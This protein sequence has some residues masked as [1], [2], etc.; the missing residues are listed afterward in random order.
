[1]PSYPRHVHLVRLNAPSEALVKRGAILLEDAL[2]TASLPGI[3]DGRLLI[4]RFLNVGNIDT[5]Q[6]AASLALIVEKRLW[7]LSSTAIHAENPGANDALAVYFRDETEP[8]ICLAKRLAQQASTHAWFWSKAIPDWQPNLSKNEALHRLIFGVMQISSKMVAV[9]ALITELLEVKAIDPLLSV[10]SEQDGAA[11][12]R[13][14]GWLKPDI[15]IAFVQPLTTTHYLLSN[16]AWFDLLQRWAGRWGSDDTRSIWLAAIALIAEKP[17]RVLDPLLMYQAQQL[18][19]QVTAWTDTRKAGEEGTRK[20]SDKTIENSLS[21]FSSPSSLFLEKETSKQEHTDK[22]DK[23]IENSLA[24]FSSP[25]SLFLEKGTSKQ[26]H[27]DN[28][29]KTIESSFLTLPTSPSSEQNWSEIPRLTEYAGLFFLFP[30]LNSLDITAFLASHPHFIELDLPRRLLY[31]VGQR[32][33]IPADDPLWTMLTEVDFTTKFTHSEFIVPA[34]WRLGVWKAGTFTIHRVIDDVNTR[35]LFD[36]SRRLALA[37]WQ[38]KASDRLRD[39]IGE[40]SFRKDNS[41][42]I[43]TNYLVIIHTWLTAMRRWCRRYAHIGLHDLVHR[44][45]RVLISRTHVDILFNHQ[46]ADI[47]IRRVGLDINPGWVPWFGR[48]V[49]FHYLYGE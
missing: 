5:R 13:I 16:S 35:V 6:S 40:N 7:Q 31:A 46:Q 26:E 45:G 23:T 17:V 29:D 3:E 1:M 39:L 21:I 48:V 10:L 36:D 19:T 20:Q 27:T 42:V 34:S 30:L 12:L 32:L 33:C 24:I 8:Y 43:P 22:E 18:I 2:H 14:C 11:L 28:E 15:A 47:R 38:G 4:I 9:V 37:L 44:S 41:V 25:S 49:T